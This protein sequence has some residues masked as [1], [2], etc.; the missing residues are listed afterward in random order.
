MS[1]NDSTDKKQISYTEFF[2]NR[3]KKHDAEVKKIILQ[4]SVPSSRKKRNY[5]EAFAQG[6][7]GTAFAQG[8]PYTRFTDELK[9]IKS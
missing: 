1:S 3:F 6:P 9:S 5:Q 2:R 8:P 7:T 4:I